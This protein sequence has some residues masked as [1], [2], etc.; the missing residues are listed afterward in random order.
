VQQG[1]DA[2]QVTTVGH[3][4][5]QP[6]SQTKSANRRVELRVLTSGTADAS[7]NG[8]GISS[9]GSNGNG[10]TAAATSGTRSSGNA[11]PVMNK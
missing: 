1:I 6:K 8:A 11:Q 2:G 7:W 4:D 9:G 3:G 10:R 5:S